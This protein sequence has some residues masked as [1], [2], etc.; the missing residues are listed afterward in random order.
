MEE[1]KVKAPDK[2]KLHY[3]MFADMWHVA[4]ENAYVV[5]VACMYGHES[6]ISDAVRRDLRVKTFEHS[7]ENARKALDLVRSLNHAKNK[8]ERDEKRLATL[9]DLWG[10][11]DD[12]KV[13]FGI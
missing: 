10:P 7:P 3:V 8:I 9:A 5:W 11:C 2:Q 1:T 12:E 6:R 13:V 4:E